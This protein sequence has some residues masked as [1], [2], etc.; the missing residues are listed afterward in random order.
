MSSKFLKNSV[1]YSE[2]DQFHKTLIPLTNKYNDYYN[3]SKNQK[4]L[5]TY[6]IPNNNI[7][8]YCF[9]T[10]KG[11][12]YKTLYFFPENKTELNGDFFMEIDNTA[13]NWECN[14]NGSIFEGF[15][16]NNNTF[17]IT[18]ALIINCNVV[19]CDY[20][21]RYAL[22]NNIFKTQIEL[23]G[24]VYIGI[25][26]MFEE[27]EDKDTC[28]LYD[29]FKR[30]FKYGTEINCIEYI[31]NCSK[32]RRINKIEYKDEYKQITKGKYVDVYNVHNIDTNDSEGILYVKTINDSL[33]LQELT[34]TTLVVKMLCKYNTEY[35]KW[36][37]I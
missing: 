28:S 6:L 31:N 13:I 2:V 21:L 37:P 20:P 30:N 24:H 15:L 17:Y 19:S 27:N 16:Y 4:N 7:K 1:N 34:E 33:K 23:N 22:I 26:S 35:N 10:N 32:I 29:I 8:Y 5:I 3:S 12:N 36:Q 18:D 11:N 9:V 25:H 14:G